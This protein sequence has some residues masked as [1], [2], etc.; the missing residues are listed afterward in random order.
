MLPAQRYKKG[1]YRM[2]VSFSN[3]HTPS[4]VCLDRICLPNS[5][6]MF[7]SGIQWVDRSPRLNAPPPLIPDFLF[8]TSIA[9]PLPLSAGGRRQ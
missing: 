8:R 1:E 9:F 2:Q 7:I 4:G 6:A 5:L 3:V